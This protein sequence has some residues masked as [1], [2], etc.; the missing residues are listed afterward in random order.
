MTTVSDAL[1]RKES[2]DV[3]VA[4]ELYQSYL[5]QGSNHS[6]ALINAGRNLSF[7]QYR[8]LVN[9]TGMRSPK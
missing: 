3:Q 9:I 4:Y 7:D 8:E 5:R 2:H 6:I 1:A